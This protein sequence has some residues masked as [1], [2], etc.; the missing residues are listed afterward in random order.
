MFWHMRTTLRLNDDLLRAAKEE[1]ARSG[2]TLTAVV[3]GALRLA[4]VR[5]SD[6][7]KRRR[8]RLPTFKGRLRPGVDLD[9]G[10]ALRDLMD[11]DE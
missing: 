3:E 2:R 4:L 6:V 11:E 9:D 1:A 5:G 8:V 10:V 7:A